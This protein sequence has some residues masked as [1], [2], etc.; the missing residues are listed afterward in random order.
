MRSPTGL[1]TG[2]TSLRGV[3]RIVREL[4]SALQ[5]ARL[6][7]CHW[8]GNARLQE[9]VVGLRDLDILVDREGALGLSE[10][11]ATVGFKRFASSPWEAV[12]ALEDYIALDADTGRLLHLHLHYRLT[13]GDRLLSGYRLP[14]E[15]LVLSTRAFDT[16]MAMYVADPHMELLLLIARAAIGLGPIDRIAGWLGR[17]CLGALARSDLRWLAART[18]PHRLAELSEGCLGKEA[19][20]LLLDMVSTGPSYRLLRALKRRATPPLS[21]YRTYTAAD[22]IVRR[23]MR[24]LVGLAVALN[25]RIL[26]SLVIPGRTLP[27]GGLVIA[28]EGDDEN[29]RAT[30]VDR[31]AAW[32]TWKLDV[33]VLHGGGDDGRRRGFARA[34]TALVRARNNRARRRKA[35]RARSRG[36]I[37]LYDGFPQSQIRHAGGA[38]EPAWEADPPDLIIKLRRAPR[39]GPDGQGDAQPEEVRSQREH[40]STPE[41]RPTLRTVDIDLDQPPEQRLRVVQRAL[42]ERV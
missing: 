41:G 18:D 24:F 17:P 28:F 23:G 7:Y 38:P 9:A 21:A 14:W 29:A 36:M 39:P 31:I 8:K 3:P 1:A 15:A 30:L 35:F 25:R 32:L 6:S 40:V 5:T 16:T 20:R 22:A 11:L 26:R 4:T 33:L 37:V 42:W 27:S 34:L 19:T 10:I 13:V 2:E 12:P